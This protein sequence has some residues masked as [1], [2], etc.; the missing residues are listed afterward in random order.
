MSA[1]SHATPFDGV[2]LV[3]GSVHLW[4]GGPKGDVFAMRPDLAY[5][6][7]GIGRVVLAAA[8][9]RA[10]QAG[11]VD[12]AE[13]I[14]LERVRDTSDRGVL[15]TLG[16]GLNP[17]WRDLLVI[18]L[19]LEDREAT[20]R[21][22]ARLGQAAVAEA[23][24]G[25][26]LDAGALADYPAVPPRVTARAA[27]GAVLRLEG[28]VGAAGLDLLLPAMRGVRYRWRVRTRLDDD[29]DIATAGSRRA[30]LV[31]EVA[32]WRTAAGWAAAAVAFTDAEDPWRAEYVMGDGFRRVVEGVGVPQVDSEGGEVR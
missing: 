6:S 31:E 25:L 3:E 15:A 11:E 12:P 7:A 21:L 16:A 13:R 19:T 22:S 8:F 27:A 28:Y 1:P 2:D 24:A 9:A 10:M 30:S 23:A 17:T 18:A 26:G 29:W 14:L 20:A 4:A 5:A 32:L